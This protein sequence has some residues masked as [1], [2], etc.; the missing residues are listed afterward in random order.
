MSSHLKTTKSLLQSHW[1]YAIRPSVRPS[2][3][4]NWT[5]NALSNG[6]GRLY[7]LSVGVIGYAPTHFY[8]LCTYISLFFT[9]YLSLSLSLLRSI[10]LSFTL[11]LS[12]SF[13]LLPI[14]NYIYWYWST[15]SSIYWTFGYFH[16]HYMASKRPT[17]RA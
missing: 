6:I 5:R 17:Y 11:C 15:L 3:H 16:I 7:A 8:T 1:G 13:T 4:S 14:L 10:S 12:L 2:V 9:L